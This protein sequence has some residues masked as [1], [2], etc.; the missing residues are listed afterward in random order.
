MINLYSYHTP[1]HNELYN[2][3]FV[4]TM[5]D[6]GIT[7]NSIIDSDQHC[8]SARFRE[9]GWRQTQI[10]KV[11]TWI[12]A[13]ESNS[14]NIIICSDVDI[15]WFKP[16]SGRVES[17]LRGSDFA[18]QSYF[19]GFICSGFFICRCTDNVLNMWKS[20]LKSLLDGKSDGEQGLLLDRLRSKCVDWVELPREYYTPSKTYSDISSI[21][22]NIPQDIVMHHATYTVGINNKIKQLERVRSVVSSRMAFL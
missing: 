16:I 18:V 19:D 1:S 12:N 13:I 6:D 21:D 11:K 22:K 4:K 20:V 5:C 2:N 9:S 3:W 17:D 10:N 7:T 8:E 14:N 15:Q